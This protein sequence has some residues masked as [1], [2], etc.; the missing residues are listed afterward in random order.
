MC[1]CSVQCERERKKNMIIQEEDVADYDSDTELGLQDDIE[2]GAFEVIQQNTLRIIKM[3]DDRL[4][5]QQMMMMNGGSDQMSKGMNMHLAKELKFLSLC[6]G[7]I[8]LCLSRVGLG[9]NDCEEGAIDLEKVETPDALIDML[10]DVDAR[11]SAYVELFFMDMRLMELQMDDSGGILLYT[12]CTWDVYLEMLLFTPRF[13]IATKKGLLATIQ[14]MARKFVLKHCPRDTHL[15]DLAVEDSL[16]DYLPRKPDKSAWLVERLYAIVTATPLCPRA[17]LVKMEFAM[18]IAAGFAHYKREPYQEPWEAAIKRRYFMFSEEL[19]TRQMYWRLG[20]KV[21]TSLASQLIERGTQSCILHSVE[22][23]NAQMFKDLE[24]EAIREEARKKSQKRKFDLSGGVDDHYNAPT[25]R[26]GRDRNGNRARITKH[27]LI[28]SVMGD[29]DATATS[30]TTTTDPS[31]IN[32]LMDMVLGI[33]TTTPSVVLPASSPPPGRGPHCVNLLNFWKRTIAYASKKGLQYGQAQNLKNMIFWCILPYGSSETSRVLQPLRI[34]HPISFAT[35]HAWPGDFMT[36]SFFASMGIKDILE[37]YLTLTAMDPA[38]LER[39]RKEIQKLHREKTFKP[40][41]TQHDPEKEI[42][43]ESFY[44]PLEGGKTVVEDPDLVYINYLKKEGVPLFMKDLLLR[45]V[46]T[47]KP[48]CTTHR[49]ICIMAALCL[50]D[51]HFNTFDVSVFLETHLIDNPMNMNM[52]TETGCVVKI[53]TELG[54]ITYDGRL[55]RVPDQDPIVFIY[56]YIQ[57]LASWETNVSIQNAALEFNK[58][59]NS[60]SV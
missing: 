39:V 37:S 42:P 1:V 32:A 53:G 54:M 29:A 43:V 25:R 17:D 44:V 5:A 41:K 50:I 9:L 52:L 30:T 15:L 48:G 21:S 31:D 40:P 56:L 60:F 49:R 13:V 11:I 38:K 18:R 7:T 14:G 2:E 4:M 12:G 36:A 6:L 24:K 55:I 47:F 34:P 45:L 59:I 10:S 8:N 28:T 51:A 35:E 16:V 20:L 3:C 33:N 22:T 27:E 19:A 26:S 46:S 57:I 58:I 23:I